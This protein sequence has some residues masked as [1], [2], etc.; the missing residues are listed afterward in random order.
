MN[1]KNKHIRDKSG[2][3]IKYISSDRSYNDLQLK[4]DDLV[5]F[6]TISEYMQGSLDIEDVKNDPDFQKTG[7]LVKEMISDYNKNSS[8]KKEN[9]KFIRD[10]FAESASEDK[11]IEDICQIKHE[12][13]KNDLDLVTAEWV[14]EWHAKKQRNGGREPE[15]EIKDFITSS[16]KS[17][18]IKSEKILSEAS[19]KRSNRKFSVR[20]LSLAAAAVIGAFI[21]VRSLLPSYNPEEL[22]N[23]YYEP[24]NAISPVTR[25]INNVETGSFASAIGSY[26]K[27]DYQNASMGFSAAL[28]K[29]NSS[30]SSR[31]FLGLTQIALGNYNQAVELLTAVVS[32]GSE[33]GKE[34]R[35]YLGLTYLK[36][37]NK[38]K[39]SECFEYLSKSN[40]FYRDRSEKILCRLK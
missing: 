24:L 10:I 33:Y 4:N 28:Q 37:G 15:N 34:A 14:N 26:K 6:G 35:W 31:F 3:F 25:S 21:L 11:V 32:D 29:D 1:N 2:P 12:T 23:S 38:P 16:L 30:V 20:Y 5:L 7:D 19:G 40:G 22:F 18:I 17:D 39:A 13:G 9:E 36:T 27:G 8:V